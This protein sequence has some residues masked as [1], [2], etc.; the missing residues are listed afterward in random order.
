MHPGFEIA[1]GLHGDVLEPSTA[2]A[3]IGLIARRVCRAFHVAPVCTTFGTL[4]RPRLRSKLIPFGFNP[5]LP[6]TYQGNQFAM[7]GGFILFLCLHYN[8][9]VSGEQ[10]GGSVM[11]RLNIYERLLD[12]GFFSIKFPFCNWGT[13][14]QKMSWWLA[15]NPR[16]QQL[17]DVCHCGAAG[18]HFRVR[19]T[20]DR[21]RLAQ[22]NK[23][24]RPSAKSVFG[25]EPR[26]GEHVARF[27]G[28]YPIPLCDYVANLNRKQIVSENL[29]RDP[30]IER[31]SS[32]PPTWIGQLGRSLAWK[33][34][35]QFAF[36]KPNHINVNEQLSYRSLLKHVSKSSPHSRFCALLDSRV[37][38]GCNAKGRSSSKQLNFYLTSALPY[39]VGGDLY[40]YLLHIGSADNSSDDIS[41]FVA[42]RTPSEPL[43]PW[44][45]ALLQG[46]YG[47]FDQ[48]VAAD[49]LAKPWS[50]WARLIRLAILFSCN[51]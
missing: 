43:P 13:P 3:I 10:P 20:F 5:D 33:K 1:D 39:I 21:L 42:L 8:L 32:T 22:F 47:L 34:V 31:P 30:P 9:L 11:F 23:L 7:R 4:R 36:K 37:V 12:A 50:S 27:S 44:L 45:R 40:P 49:K 35:I 51:Q 29:C 46:D 28:G 16:L 26:R 48:V 24:C 25:R 6:E 2:L 41:R 15:N 17:S 14:F 18:S 19:G 38:I